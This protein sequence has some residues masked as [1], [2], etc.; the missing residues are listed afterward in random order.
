M[1]G[2]LLSWKDCMGQDIIVKLYELQLVSNWAFHKN[3]YVEHQDDLICK[4]NL[5]KKRE[6]W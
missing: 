5:I 2:W 3:V 6:V 4:K 1:E